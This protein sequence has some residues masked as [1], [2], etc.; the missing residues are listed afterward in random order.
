MMQQNLL[1]GEVTAAIVRDGQCQRCLAELGDV[2]DG[3]PC[4]S[5]VGKAAALLVER[6]GL[7]PSTADGYAR[8]WS[9]W[10]RFAEVA[11]YPA[12]LAFALPDPA[13]DVAIAEHLASLRV[14]YSLAASTIAKEWAYL[15]GYLGHASGSSG[16][17]P[18]L[19]R[20]GDA[21]RVLREITRLSA[22][23]SKE[24][25]AAI[26]PEDLEVIVRALDVEIA[27]GRHPRDRLKPT[28]DTALLLVG[29]SIAARP[30]E[31]AGMNW[32][33]ISGRPGGGL[34]VTVSYLGKRGSRTIPVLSSKS[35]LCPVRAMAHW[36]MA[37]TQA[38]K[39]IPDRAGDVDEAVA[40][41][42]RKMTGPVFP[43]IDRH[44][45][46]LGRMSA[47]S[48]STIIVERATMALG[49]N[50]WTGKSLRAGLAVSAL[51]AEIPT[52]QIRR[53]TGHRSDK[54]LETYLRDA[55][56]RRNR[57]LRLL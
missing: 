33:G 43:R 48:I 38:L 13:A 39:A 3:S 30:G 32:T 21:S 49:P 44:R 6:G 22:F 16:Q 15:R 45:R 9:R 23:E 24:H 29:F 5:C 14:T 40:E 19:V 56:D 34:D 20:G 35:A 27:A 52:P 31:L 8:A 54:S 55:Q 41:L 37:F 25:T 47:E 4:L 50:E 12:Q 7:A 10:E 2:E 11:G 57:A 1:S 26:R 36:N 42:G 28:R 17:P 46:I 51:E 18:S 53:V